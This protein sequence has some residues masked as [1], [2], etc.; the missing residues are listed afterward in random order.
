MRSGISGEMAISAQ[1]KVMNKNNGGV[2]MASSIM[3]LN[4][5]YE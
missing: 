4:M 5:A 3:A 1:R 2:G